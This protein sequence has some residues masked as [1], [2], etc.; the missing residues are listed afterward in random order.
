M[1]WARNAGFDVP[2][3]FVVRSSDLLGVPVS[4]IDEMPSAFAVKRFDRRE[5]GSKIHQEDLC[6]ALD[7]PPFQKY[8]ES[9]QR[10]VSLDGV[11]RFVADVAGEEQGRE[12]A[13]RIGFV[14]ASGNSDA[15]LK[16]WS[17]LW[18]NADRP[19]LAP[20]YDFVSTIAWS[21]LFGWDTAE[22]LQL[23]LGLG[24]EKDF[25][26]LTQFTLEDHAANSHCAWSKDEIM[27]GIERARDALPSIASI[28]PHSMRRAL[29]THWTRV[30]LLSGMLQ[31]EVG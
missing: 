21:N 9:G 8:Q 20:C 15:H 27:S 22:G 25:A 12:L 26:R 16:N 17:L 19:G 10:R 3:H 31:R 30:P 23:S 18:G 4:W 28:M 14:I 24:R 29:E 1:T 5:D 11:V 7:V 2:D 13:R 6:Q